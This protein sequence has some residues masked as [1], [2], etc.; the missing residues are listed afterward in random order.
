MFKHKTSQDF[1]AINDILTFLNSEKIITISDRAGRDG[2]L[3][4]PNRKYTNRMQSIKNELYN[5]K[6]IIW[7][8]IT[9]MLD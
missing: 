2:N 1:K 3:Y 8:H 6:D 4:K 9:S 7:I 5:S